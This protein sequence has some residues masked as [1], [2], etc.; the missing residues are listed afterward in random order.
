[1]NDAKDDAGWDPNLHMLSDAGS[2]SAAALVPEKTRENIRGPLDELILRGRIQHYLQ[3][4][5]QAA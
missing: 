5:R 1:L 4:W 3:L 2:P